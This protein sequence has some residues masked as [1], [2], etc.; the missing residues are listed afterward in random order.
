MVKKTVPPVPVGEVILVNKPP[1]PPPK[2]PEPPKIKE[3]SPTKYEKEIRPRAPR[4]E[5]QME[6][7]RRLGE[8]NKARAKERREALVVKEPELAVVPEDKELVRIK[9]KRVYKPRVPKE[10]PKNEVVEVTPAP[11]DTESEAEVVFKPPRIRVKPKVE[12]DE[13]RPKRV[14]R[15]AVKR[16]PAKY[17]YE[18]ETT[19]EMDESSDDDDDY[20]VQ[21]YAMKAE[22]RM[23]ALRQI[24]SRLQ[25]L[26]NPYQGRSISIF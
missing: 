21:K 1:P 16:L 11:T 4:S 9:P 2:E 23:N 10:A 15:K 13:E 7:S 12:S 25:Q 8:L 24:D 18:T 26:Q 19:T 6:H 3:I 14:V 17:A 22:K 5:K 20:K